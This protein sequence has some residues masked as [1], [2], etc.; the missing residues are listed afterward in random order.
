MKKWV[1][2]FS[3]IIIIALIG[4]VLVSKP[5]SNMESLNVQ[6]FDKDKKDF[7]EGEHIND[8]TSI[9][10][11]TDILNSATHQK[12]AFEMVHPAD[13]K[14]TIIYEDKTEDTLLV[15]TEL[16]DS[17]LLVR[18]AK[19]D[20]FRINKKSHQEAFLSIVK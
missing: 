3:G 14:I 2:L 20:L 11:L 15:W 17:V 19:T 16:G 9:E 5:F 18:P 6:K 8:P 4:Y 13:Y 12:G 7:A 10:K 1:F